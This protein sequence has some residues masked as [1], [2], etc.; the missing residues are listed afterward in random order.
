MAPSKKIKKL[1]K[2]FCEEHQKII[3]ELLLQAFK[4]GRS[5]EKKN[6][7]INYK[8]IIKKSL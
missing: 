1:Y 4:E 3:E 8:N 2:K 7:S 6:K 5:F